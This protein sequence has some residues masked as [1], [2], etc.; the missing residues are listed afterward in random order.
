VISI[1]GLD[2]RQLN[3]FWVEARFPSRRLPSGTSLCIRPD[4]FVTAPLECLA[5]FSSLMKHGLL[6]KAI[7]KGHVVQEILDLIAAK[8]VPVSSHSSSS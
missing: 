5:N 1:V 2:K 3:T 7:Q 4:D 8:I 6:H